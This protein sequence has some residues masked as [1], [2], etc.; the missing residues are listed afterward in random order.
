MFFEPGYL[1]YLPCLPAC[2][3]CVFASMSIDH[4]AVPVPNA[5]LP[6]H[7]ARVTNDGMVSVLAVQLRAVASPRDV[8]E[9]T[10][11]PAPTEIRQQLVRLGDLNASAGRCK[12][13]KLWVAVA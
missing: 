4:V 7:L 5:L 12:L 6:V 3:A 10:G 2:T 13:G 1:A 9:L 8:D 11:F